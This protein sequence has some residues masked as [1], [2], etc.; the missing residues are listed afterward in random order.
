MRNHS[1][2]Q[3]GVVPV[4]LLDLQLLDLCVGD[5]AAEDERV[6]DPPHDRLAL[7]GHLR[8]EDGL[9]RR[10]GGARNAVRQRG[11][12]LR[13]EGLQFLSDPSI[14]DICTSGITPDQRFCNKF[15]Y[16]RCPNLNLQSRDV[17]D[18]ESKES[19]NTHA[20]PEPP[21]EDLARVEDVLVRVLPI[22]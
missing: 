9:R 5:A 13:G 14:L 20:E 7:G 16:L 15:P 2:F 17:S 3:R 8:R 6:R 22:C 1:S 21:R 19:P 18:G 4:P 10:L 11:G 12:H